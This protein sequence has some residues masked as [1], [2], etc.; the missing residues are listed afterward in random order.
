LRLRLA[1]P[2]DVEAIGAVELSASELFAGT[3]M[4]WAVGQTTDL[5]ELCDRIA[6]A[7]VWIAEDGNGIG[8]FLITGTMDRDFYIDELSVAKSHQ[9][10]GVGRTLIEAVL[11]DAKQQGFLAATLTTDRELPWNAPY[12]ARLGFRILRPMQ[13]PPEL[14]AK[15]ASQPFPE[16]RCAMRRDL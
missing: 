1:T 16:R 12:Y 15:L 11:T 8:G 9:R 14:A 6:K 5:A 2:A 3:H 7:A 13:T 4:A 10:R